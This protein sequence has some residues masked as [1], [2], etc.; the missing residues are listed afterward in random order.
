MLTSA[1]DAKR[2]GR[3]DRR[4]RQLANVALDCAGGLGKFAFRSNKR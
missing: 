3:G 4:G 1:K 2:E